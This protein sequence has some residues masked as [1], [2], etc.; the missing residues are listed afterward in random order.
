MKYKYLKKTE[1]N[2][3]KSNPQLVTTPKEYIGFVY[4]IKHEQTGMKYIGI[5]RFWQKYT[6]PPLK[7]KKQ[8]RHYLKETKWRTYNGSGVIEEEVAEHP[9]RFE[10]KILYLCETIT[11]LKAYET[12]LILSYYINGEWSKIYNEIVGV[13]L[14]IRKDGTESK[15]EK[16]NN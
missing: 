16:S 4:E 6:L 10:K 8:K 3:F 12:W 11:K 15:A 2:T 9:E 7:G 5:K 13:R 1:K 14:R